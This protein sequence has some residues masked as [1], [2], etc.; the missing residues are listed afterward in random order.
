[1]EIKKTEKLKRKKL[2]TYLGFD[3]TIGLILTVIS[4]ITGFFTGKSF[5]Y[6]LGIIFLI[7]T[8]VAGIFISIIYN[9]ARKNLKNIFISI[10]VFIILT[11]SALIGLF[12]FK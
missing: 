6:R 11:A 3:Y 1:M 7:A 9:G 2:I 12:G 10:A 8:P 5:F 4:I